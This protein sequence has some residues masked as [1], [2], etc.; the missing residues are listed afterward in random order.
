[1]YIF[2]REILY[3]VFNV[4]LHRILDLESYKTSQ[5]FTK[6]MPLFFRRKIVTGVI[7]KVDKQELGYS[8]DY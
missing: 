2:E 3:N 6:N 8:P 7:Q 1:M 5:N 4:P